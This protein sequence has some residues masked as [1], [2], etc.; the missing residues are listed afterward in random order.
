MIKKFGR[1]TDELSIVLRRRVL[2]RLL[3]WVRPAYYKQVDSEVF[4]MHVFLTTLSRDL[5]QLFKTGIPTFDRKFKPHA[6]AH[7]GEPQLIPPHSGQGMP[8]THQ[9]L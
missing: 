6:L 1:I 8:S 5:T 4:D 7:S 2:N 9:P 3:D